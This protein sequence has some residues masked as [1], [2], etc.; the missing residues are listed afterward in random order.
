MGFDG[1]TIALIGGGR[2]GRV[3]ASNLS[4]LLTS[5]DRVVWVSRHNPDIVGD[6][7]RKLSRDDGP[8]FEL[9]TSIGSALSMGPTAAL[10]V[11]SPQTH[12]A[13]SE[14]CLRNGTHAFVEKPLSF[15]VGEAR[16][17]ISA[18]TDRNLVLAVG[19]HLL[20]ASYLHHFKSRFVTRPIAKIT[21]RWFDPA[22][23]V[24]HGESK[25]A[26]DSTPLAHDLYPHIWSIVRV[27]TDCAEQTIVGASI[28]ADGSISFESLAGAVKIEVGCGRYSAAR[29]RMIA[30]V[31]QDGGTASLD[32]TQEPGAAMLDGVSLPPDPLWGQTPRPAMAEV[33]GFLTQVS[34]PT[35]D[36]AW[37]HLA[38]NCFDSVAG[39]ET[40]HSKLR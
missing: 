12:V 6:A 15:S 38:A 17:L 31:F 1:R 26:D 18:A 5:R 22:Y 29:E 10:V 4:Q 3:H 24:R 11:T 2:W 39:A 21:L 8:A 40:L 32:F 36:L 30:L 33:Q 35:R 9:S 37:L 13:A 20:S 34:S 28:Q 14:A 7:I 27:L 19:L 16:Y 23:E 25:H